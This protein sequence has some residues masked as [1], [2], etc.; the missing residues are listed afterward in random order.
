MLQEKEVMQLLEETE[1]VLHGH[2]LLT[3]GLHSPMYV[4]KFNRHE[5][6]GDGLHRLVR[7]AVDAAGH[8]RGEQGHFRPR[9]QR[10]QDL[11]SRRQPCVHAQAGR[12]H[13]RRLR[14]PL[15]YVAREH[16]GLVPERDRCGDR[17]GHR[18]DLGHLRR[19]AD[20]GHLRAR[21]RRADAVT[22]HR[23]KIR[24]PVGFVRMSPSTVQ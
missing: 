17:E 22:V 16:C 7:H 10:N 8:R 19:A 14:Q 21:R 5:R 9:D 3:S 23:P 1:A 11:R 18:R 13:E 15:R 6:A 20:V 2:F 4:E 24:V 12:I